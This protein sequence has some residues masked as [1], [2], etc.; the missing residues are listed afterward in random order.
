MRT[1]RSGTRR[2]NRAPSRRPAKQG[3][4]SSPRLAVLAAAGLLWLPAAALA[5]SALTTD[6]EI[7][8][9]GL[10]FTDGSLQTTAAS[11]GGTVGNVLVVAASGGQYTSIQ[12]ALDA[13]G[14]ALPA[15]TAANP[16]LVLVA[17]GV[18]D[19][20]VTMKSWVHLRGSGETVTRIRA[21]GDASD[22]VGTVIGADDSRL[23]LLTV[24][25]TGGATFATAVY[26]GSSM[27]L[28]NVT[29]LASGATS[30]SIGVLNAGSNEGRLVAVTAQASGTAANYAV[31]NLNDARLDRVEATATGGTEAIGV[32]NDGGSGG[33]IQPRLIDVR[34]TASGASGENDGIFN[35]SSDALMVRVEASGSGGDPNHGVHND[36]SAPRLSLVNASAQGSGSLMGGNVTNRAIHNV[37][38]SPV[39]RSSIVEVGLSLFADSLGLQVDATSDVRLAHSQIRSTIGVDTGGAL[40]CHQVSDAFFAELACT[41]P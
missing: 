9:D 39:I 5:Q 37:A 19:E 15:A 17:P 28:H 16:Y 21:A 22:T 8:A 6:G 25:S 7:V 24:E 3:R 10:L 2:P 41:T 11:G 12:A 20:R 29:A 33:P 30:R 26:N 4:R 35:D 32:F 38:S 31:L 18:Y 23:S 27:E 40:T 13:I 1:L 36:A 34:A 14:A